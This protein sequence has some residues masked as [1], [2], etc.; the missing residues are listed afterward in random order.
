MGSRRFVWF[1][2]SFVLYILGLAYLTPLFSLLL[3]LSNLLTSSLSVESCK[4]IMEGRKGM[5]IL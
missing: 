5:K 4:R 3:T 2:V 1:L